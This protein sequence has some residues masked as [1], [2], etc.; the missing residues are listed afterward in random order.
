MSAIC[1]VVARDGRLVDTNA[2]DRLFDAAPHRGRFRDRRTDPTAVVGFQNTPAMRP[3]AAVDRLG[4]AT[5]AF[6]GRVD[7]RAELVQL[8]SPRWPEAATDDHARLVLRAFLHWGEG[9]A[10]RVIGDF[11]FVV[12]DP[13]RR[14]VY[15]ARDAIGVKPLY[16]FLSDRQ[17]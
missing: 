11:A 14:L 4:S 7:N 3:H 16:Y 6:H 15:A 12:C 9:C 2:L 1:A 8:L 17:F 13:S 10:S 5:I